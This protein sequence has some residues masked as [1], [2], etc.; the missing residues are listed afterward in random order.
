MLCTGQVRE[1]V[2]KWIVKSDKVKE[3][4]FTLSDI[5][6]GSS[7]E[8]RVS[9][10]NKAGQGPASSPSASAKYGRL[11][12]CPIY[13]AVSWCDTETDSVLSRNGMIS[14]SISTY[15]FVLLDLNISF[16]RT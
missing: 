5:K 3:K 4:T 8:F 10:V 2:G 14:K 13:A 15:S 9:A 6:E 12:S 11:R 1:N 16:T 7:Y